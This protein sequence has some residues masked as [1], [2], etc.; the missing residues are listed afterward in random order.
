M[1][2]FDIN[3]RCLWKKHCCY[4]FIKCINGFCSDYSNSV[5]GTIVFE[6]WSFH[7]SFIPHKKLLTKFVQISALEQARWKYRG[8]SML[9]L[10]LLEGKFH[11]SFISHVM[12]WFSTLFIWTLTVWLYCLQII[13]QFLIWR[14]KPLEQYRNEN[15]TERL[16]E[17]SKFTNKNQ[18]YLLIT[19]SQKAPFI[20]YNA[21]GR[22]R[23]FLNEYDNLDEFIGCYHFPQVCYRE[24]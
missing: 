18:Q 17:A 21:W 14:K 11:I 4:V 2:L 23:R 19:Q 20:Y 24:Y 15:D 16:C 22:W 3:W 13:I 7:L 8:N 1:V 5:F 9:W 6:S 12:D 10:M